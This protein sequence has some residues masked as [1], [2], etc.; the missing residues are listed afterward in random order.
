MVH[1][2]PSSIKV[3]PYE[4]I[5][6]NRVLRHPD[7]NVINDFCLVYFKADKDDGCIKSSLYYE[8]VLKSGI[9]LCNRR[10][11]LFGASNSQLRQHSYWFIRADSYKEVDEKRAKLGNFSEIT[12]VGK[13]ITRLGLWFSKTLPSKVRIVFFF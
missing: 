3:M 4:R 10:Y 9:I 2:T 1:I 8:M 12:N 5:I 13:Y 7:F 11:H 6:G